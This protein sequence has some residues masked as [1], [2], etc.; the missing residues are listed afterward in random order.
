MKIS[1]LSISQGCTG[2]AACSNICP[3]DAVSMCLRKAD[4]F[5][6]PQIDENKCVN[7]GLCGEVCPIDKKKTP[8]TNSCAYSA[9]ANDED[10][11]NSGSSGGIFQ[12]LAERVICNG[13]VV[14]GAVFD[15][16]SK[17]IQHKS[18]LEC[19]LKSILRSKYAQ[20][21]IGNAYRQVKT[22]LLQD[23]EVLF[24]GTPCQVRGLKAY[25]DRSKVKGKLLTVDFMCHG[26]PS[27]TQF[28]EFLDY[29]EVKRGAPIC[30]VTFREKDLGWHRQITKVY[31]SDHS[32]WR[33][34]SLFWFHH[35]YFVRNYSLRDSCYNCV[36]YASHQA[37]ITLADYWLIPAEKDD[38]KGTS[39]LLV[40]TQDGQL[41][42]DEIKQ[43]VSL[44]ALDWQSEDYV[45]FS[46]INYNKANKVI[47]QRHYEKCG[48][49]AVKTRLLWK[50]AG[51]EY[52]S[53]YV[54]RVLGKIKR[55]LVHR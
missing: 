34:E 3:K 2:C 31:F 19:S 10:I 7:C 5:Y 20:S 11:R 53:I 24:S 23:R 14:F 36:E 41:L 27:P 30:D 47:W 35:Y 48:L 8:N 26:V 33:K 50:V 9:F 39:L 16:Q 13:G 42:L 15:A 4:G 38:N 6:Y 21:T 54:K 40:N 32:V 44:D 25:L 55:M 22:L 37:D 29:L 51:K 49:K 1:E 17:T 28:K 18:T 52:I 43:R 12:L 46:H 45:I